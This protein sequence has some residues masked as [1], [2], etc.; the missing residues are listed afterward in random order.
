MKRA[1]QIFAAAVIITSM[2]LLAGCGSN[3]N[4]GNNN[5]EPVVENPDNNFDNMANNDAMTDTDNN[6]DAEEPADAEP[7]EEPE[8]TTISLTD[9]LG[10]EVTLEGPAQ[11]VVGL[12]PS[13]VEILFAVGAGDQ[14]VGREEFTNYPEEAL[15]IPS[16]GG[17][18][19]ELNTEAI[20]SVEP[21]LVIVANLTTPEQVQSLEDLGLTVF[22]LGNPATL[23]EMYDSLRTVATLTGHEEETEEVI[24]SLDARVQA[25]VDVIANAS[26]APL[27]FYQLDSTDP[28]A[29]YTSG[30]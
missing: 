10:R 7:V 4:G 28:N 22:L 18:F 27:V 24:A 14:V 29:P 21:D 15:E 11:R 19:G 30:P 12:A 6:T 3:Q 23:E 16:M 20:L 5:T 2:V 25:V 8:P 13:V 17:S 9:G 26:D 1:L